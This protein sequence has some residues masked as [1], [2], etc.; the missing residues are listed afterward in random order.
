MMPRLLDTALQQRANE[1]DAAA[2]FEL[3][4]ALARDGRH[5]D[6]LGWLA[7]AAERGHPRACHQLGARLLVGRAAPFDP[8]AGRRLLTTAADGGIPAARALLAVIAVVAGRP[9]DGVAMLRAA[10]EAGDPEAAAQ[11]ALL[12]A[13]GG[14]DIERWLR[15]PAGRVLREAPR[16]VVFD[17]LLPRA[18]C[19]W[20]I[21]RA[22][23]RL[24]RARVVDPRTSE[25]SPHPLRTNSGA[26]FGLLESDVIIQLA[27]QRI[28]AAVGSPA[29]HQEPGNVLHYRP[30][31]QYR[32]HLDWIAPNPGNEAELRAT[33]QRE[34]TCLVYLN[35]AYAGGETTF[36]E[37]DW[38]FRGRPGDALV[39]TNMHADGSADRRTR[40]AGTPPDSGEKWLYSVW[41]REREYPLA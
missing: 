19:D 34:R 39:F 38:R 2:Q 29:A 41:I 18:W 22:Q 5:A 24:E 23:P 13:D 25:R 1:G 14:L 26:G 15:P 4:T 9:V 3:A 11:L 12:D 36:P 32:L 21:R 31:E 28:A 40:H 16:I 33:G 37:L 10:A 27:N 30:G 17:A 20:L 8:R 6:A 35:D 7:R